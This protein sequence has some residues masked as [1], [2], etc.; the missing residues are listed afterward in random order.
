MAS[1]LEKY[2]FAIAH[3]KH[4]VE[5]HHPERLGEDQPPLFPMTLDDLLQYYDHKFQLCTYR[6]TR[7]YISLLL[8]HPK[9]GPEWKRDIYDSYLVGEKRSQMREAERNGESNIQN[10]GVLKPLRRR[11]RFYTYIPPPAVVSEKEQIYD[12]N[13]ECH[14]IQGVNKGELLLIFVFNT[15]NSG[16]HLLLLSLTNGSTTF[17]FFFL[18]IYSN[19]GYVISTTTSKKQLLPTPSLS[20]PSQQEYQPIEK[21]KKT[22][23]YYLSEEETLKKDKRRRNEKLGAE[24]WAI[25]NKMNTIKLNVSQ[26]ASQVHI[27][28]YATPISHTS[29]MVRG[30]D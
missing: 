9:H 4:F 3:Y 16:Y 6:A 5:K 2:Q 10:S 8:H 21:R 15:D 11:S 14:V 23:N 25:P 13:S 19:I 20:P 22:P 1:F 26:L 17:F 29:R 12:N 27:T 18:G 28:S 24:K 30:T 7:N